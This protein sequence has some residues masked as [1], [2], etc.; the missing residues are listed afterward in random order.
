MA[1]LLLPEEFAH[2]DGLKSQRVFQDWYDYLFFFQR[3]KAGL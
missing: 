2:D 1:E 3:M